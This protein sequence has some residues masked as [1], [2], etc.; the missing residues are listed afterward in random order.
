M[1]GFLSALP[2]FSD[3]QPESDAQ[4]EL[5]A[6]ISQESEGVA[7]GNGLSGVSKY[8]N[9]MPVVTGVNRY[10]GRQEVKNT[11]YE[12]PSK[13]EEYIDRL[14]K[15]TGVMRYLDAN[16]GNV[17]S[18]VT[19][20]LKKQDDTEASGV[21]K[22]MATKLLSRGEKPKVSSVEAYLSQKSVVVVKEKP[23]ASSVEEYMSKNVRSA[24]ESTV[25]K[26]IAKKN[27]A[28][29]VR[30]DVTGVDKYQ[31]EQELLAKKKE[32]EEIVARYLE[33]QAALAKESVAAEIEAATA[34]EIAAQEEA[35]T[36]AQTEV[37]NEGD[38]SAVALYLKKQAALA[39]DK[40]AMT[41]VSKY[42]IAKMLEESQKPAVS[43]VEKYLAGKP[44]VEKEVKEISSVDKYL[45]GKEAPV[46]SGVEKYVSTKTII[47]SHKPEI[48]GVARYMVRVRYVMDVAVAAVSKSL[49]G[50][51]IP[52]G[53]K[54]DETSVGRYLDNKETLERESKPSRV[55]QYL[56]SLP[57]KEQEVSTGVDHYL[58]EQAIVE[59]ET[60]VSGV[61]KYLANNEVIVT[62]APSAEDIAEDD[63][64]DVIV[65]AEDANVVALTGV[66]QYL[67]EKPEPEIVEKESAVEEVIVEL[68]GV[69]K[70]LQAKPEPEMMQEEEVVVEL[71]GVE[72]YMAIQAVERAT[73]VEK[74]LM[75]A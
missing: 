15:K 19:K 42:L 62:E 18:G 13:V 75:N 27:I 8:V 55:S 4:S 41:G 72:K 5:G 56:D 60:R 23:V 28:T 12:G 22:Y 21:A 58:E 37:E 17:L 59:I 63:E 7:Q 46:L 1:K 16:E 51:F 25:G 71:S 6:E 9:N 67:Q 3:K 54:L 61:E 52:A 47:D 29:R 30:F 10:I 69:D 49:E 53:K 31:L 34:A 20:Y 32:A 44:T 48:S 33:N 40:P 64:A 35:E 66:D 14:P 26:Y 65:I 57:E 24:A 11:V 50:E 43:G 36:L 74:Y 70:Y 68:T 38:L 2:F 39:K 73:G 45:E